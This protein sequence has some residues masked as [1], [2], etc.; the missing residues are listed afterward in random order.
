MSIQKKGDPKSRPLLFYRDFSLFINWRVGW[1]N[2]LSLSKEALGETSKVSISWLL[3]SYY[4]HIDHHAKKSQNN[5][6]K[7]WNPW[8]PN[9]EVGSMVLIIFT[10]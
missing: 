9:N 5:Y 8:V 4:E 2:S 6:N 7:Y 3:L 1:D 10:Q